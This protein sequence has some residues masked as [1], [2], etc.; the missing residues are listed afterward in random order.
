MMQP[1][2]A[3]GGPIAFHEM[4]FG[5][6]IAY[7][8]LVMLWERLLRAR[9]PEWKYVLLMSVGSSFYVVNHYLNYA[10]FYYWLINSCTLA[11]AYLWY[12]V[13]VRPAAR[14]RGWQIAAV[15]AGVAFTVIYISFELL[16]RRLVGLGLHE[17]WIMVSSY[18][19]LV[20]VVIWRGRSATPATR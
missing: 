15:A 12:R 13:G 4:L 20:G 5:T 10:P 19:G 6:W 16:A 14:S 1:D 2:P 11:F 9:L 8:V 18:A 3:W 7:I 17:F